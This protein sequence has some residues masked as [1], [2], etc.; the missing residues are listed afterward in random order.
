MADYFMVLDFRCSFP[1]QLSP[2]AE[3]VL[4]SPSFNAFATFMH[5]QLVTPFG[6]FNVFSSQ[7]HTGT[8]G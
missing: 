2:S 7:A 8:L 6:I 3:F 4:S 1:V 5:S